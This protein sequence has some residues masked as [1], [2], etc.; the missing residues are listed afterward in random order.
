MKQRNAA[1]AFSSKSI[2]AKNRPGFHRDGSQKGLYLKV[3]E[4]TDGGVS[5]SWVYRFVS[6]VTGRPRWMGLGEA[7][8]IS[9]AAAREL[10]RAARETQTLGGDPI[11]ARREQRMAAKLE[12]AKRITFGKC[13]ADYVA[14]H[15]AGWGNAKHTKQW[16]ST[17]EGDHAATAAINGLPVAAIDTA[18]VLRVLRPLWRKKPETA[19]RIRGRIERVLAWATV[20][21]FRRGENPARWRGHLAEMLPA[22]SKIHKVKHHTA[23]PYAEL[24]AFMAKLRDK[25][26]VSAHALEFTILAATRT[27][28]TIGARWS[29]INLKEKVWTVPAARMKSKRVHRVPLSDRALKI[30]GSVPREGDFVFP[31][32]KAKRHMAAAG[33]LELLQGMVG[34]GYTVHGFRSTFRDWTKE[35]TSYPREIAELALAHVVA[36]KSEAAYSRG[37]ALDKRRQLMA[38]W[39]R[40]C[41]STPRQATDNVTSIRAGA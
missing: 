18:L 13:A 28:E 31:G 6:P 32:T 9:L 21:E 29:E 4:T 30:L 35:Q 24:P 10:A 22:K 15:Q 11:E 23:L 3:A 8:V 41:A 7:S 40:Y 33:M 2:K 26:S 34:N 38:A 1:K 5:K 16:R 14:E 12:A 17:F 20:S 36:D 19:S 39:A 37:D 27:S 25:G